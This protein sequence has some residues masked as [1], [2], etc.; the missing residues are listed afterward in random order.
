MQVTSYL[1]LTVIHILLLLNRN[2]LDI[3]WFNTQVHIFFGNFKLKNFCQQIQK[4]LGSCTQVF[5]NCIPVVTCSKDLQ[6]HLIISQTSLYTVDTKKVEASFHIVDKH[7]H[8][9]V[10]E[11]PVYEIFHFLGPNNHTVIYMYMGY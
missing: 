11:V 3:F 2:V 5:A 8:R 9:N 7:V 1:S 10:L 6:L 4:P